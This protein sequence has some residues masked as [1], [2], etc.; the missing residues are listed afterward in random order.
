MPADI[1]SDS[2]HPAAQPIL[3]R[4]SVT[5][6]ALV[7][8]IAIMSFLAA[9]TVGGVRIVHDAT[10]TWRGD[11]AR[12]ATIEVKPAPG[13]DLDADI[14][15]ALAIARQNPAVIEARAYSKQE[16][17]QLLEPW[18][19]AGV[20]LGLLPVPRLIRLKLNAAAT[21]D[22]AAL[23]QALAAS[24]TG[25]TLDDHRAWS[26]RLA[27]IANAVTF[28]GFAVL[29]LVMAATILSVSFATRGAVAANRGIVEV[30][31]FVG[32]RD[33]YIAAAFQRHFLVVG[34]KGGLLG[35]VAA[36]ALFTL[37]RFA[38]GLFDT[39]PNGADAALFFGHFA[40]DLVGYGEIAAA[41]ALIAAITALGS[42]WT[43]H[44]TLRAIA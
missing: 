27:S 6:N 41:V 34:L 31:H 15:S 13:R 16:A 1:D 32:A 30:L 2:D 42:R 11:V 23:R 21:G 38:E 10:T 8:V 20:D 7:A 18:L 5:G 37:T 17:E 39:L 36:A 9:L 19:G 3:P 14:A 33:S 26:S 43:V 24:G 40:L 28:T 12:E 29:A 4:D 25:A 44:R 35:G 22:L